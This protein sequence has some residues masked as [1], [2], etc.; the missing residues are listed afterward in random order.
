MTGRTYGASTA[1]SA[2]PA[3]R[4][5]RRHRVGQVAADHVDL[6]GMVIGP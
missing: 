6:A 3:A 5:R 1:S 2:R 4:G